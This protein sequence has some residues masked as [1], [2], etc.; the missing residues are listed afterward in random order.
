MDR[1]L[2]DCAPQQ[3]DPRCRLPK[4]PAAPGR[5]LHPSHFWNARIRG[6]TATGRHQTESPVDRVPLLFSAFGPILL[7]TCTLYWGCRFA[8]YGNKWP[9]Q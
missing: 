1:N 7:Q 8:G 5:S 6:E 3:R 9:S 2:C 4:I